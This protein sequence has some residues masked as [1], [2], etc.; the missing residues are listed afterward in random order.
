MKTL[1]LILLF[2]MVYIS[3]TYGQ[4][5]MDLWPN[6]PP[7]DLQKE[8][9]KEER[10]EGSDGVTRVRQIQT[11]TLKIYAPKKEI[12]TGTAV[13]ICPGGGY[14]ILAIDKEGYKIAEYF[15]SI[16]VTGIVLKYRLPDDELVSNKSIVPLMDAQ[17]AIRMVR[18]NAA[19]WNIDPQKIGI[20]GFSAGG[21]LAATASTH[22]NTVVGDVKSTTSV[23][24][25]FS[26]L[27]YPVITCLEHGHAGSR[28][29]LIGEKATPD[30]VYRF[31]NELWVN[32]DTPPVLLIHASDDHA[33]PVEN[34][35]RYYQQCV[36][37]G[38]PA[39][40]HI[41]E[42]GGHGFGMYGAKGAG[43][44]W[45]EIM[46]DWMRERKLVK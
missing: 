42:S 43:K 25:D 8:D 45:P 15:Q 31:S 13:I 3:A 33:V 41:F 32:K 40:M 34:S 9:I 6:V 26:I 7:N 28:I 18:E 16:G 19:K 38:V 2:T 20:M 4:K 14:H 12:N 29:N 5:E 10:V 30:Q 17:Q 27:V 23:R 46:T 39:S 35:I 21:H 36:K 1:K 11:P 22:F 44:K 24:P 37:N